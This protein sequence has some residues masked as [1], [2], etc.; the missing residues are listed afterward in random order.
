MRFPTVPIPSSH[1]WKIFFS[2]SIRNDPTFHLI[3][4][5]VEFF[6]DIILAAACRLRRETSPWKWLGRRA[7][8][9]NEF[10]RGCAG[11]AAFRG[12]IVG[13]KS[14]WLADV[15]R[16]LDLSLVL[17]SFLS[18]PDAFHAASTLVTF[19]VYVL[20]T[21]KHRRPSERTVNSNESKHLQSLLS[22]AFP[23]LF[24][25]LSGYKLL[26]GYQDGRII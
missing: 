16:N 2:F 3:R 13:W 19:F 9:T 24:I 6:I 10:R 17:P 21:G 14:A 4:P 23:L 11:S 18:R 5:I 20:Q 22:S 15:R 1:P 12:L 7:G 8:L 25:L 26:S